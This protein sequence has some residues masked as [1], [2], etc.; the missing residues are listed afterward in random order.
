M[1]N[2]MNEETN[3]TREQWNL[4]NCTNKGEKERNCKTYTN[5][6]LIASLKRYTQENHIFK[7]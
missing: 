6:F 5:V 4:R 1:N 3:S 2:A 7:S